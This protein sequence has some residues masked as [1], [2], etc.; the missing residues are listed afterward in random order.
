MSILFDFTSKIIPSHT[1]IDELFIVKLATTSTLSDSRIAGICTHSIASRMPSK[2]A[3]ASAYATELHRCSVL[4]ASSRIRPLQ[5]LI[6][7]PTLA[8][9][10]SALNLAS[11]L[12]LAEPSGGAVHLFVCFSTL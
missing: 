4:H 11:T 7:T 8:S 6:I 10:V 9:L 12:I 5:S 2:H 3:S 1:D